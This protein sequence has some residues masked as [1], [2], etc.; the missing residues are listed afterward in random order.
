MTAQ[1]CH[2]SYESKCIVKLNSGIFFLSIN[3][4]AFVAKDNSHLTPQKVREPD[5]DPGPGLIEFLV[6]DNCSE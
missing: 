5:R 2:L 3:I 6:S 1:N 4:P